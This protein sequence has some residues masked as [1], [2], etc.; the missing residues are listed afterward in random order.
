MA[1]VYVCVFGH[2]FVV[3]WLLRR[4]DSTKEVV[5]NFP[6]EWQWLERYQFLSLVAFRMH[7]R[8]RLIT[9]R[10]I[11]FWKR[12]PTTPSPSEFKEHLVNA[13]GHIYAPGLLLGSSVRGREI[14]FTYLFQLVKFCA[15]VI[16]CKNSLVKNPL[17]LH[18]D[19]FSPY[20]DISLEKRNKEYKNTQSP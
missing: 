11:G 3:R 4:D 8:K 18:N 6:K 13:S 12:L 10:V 15:H 17:K 19:A 14:I 20:F 1:C 16:L 5:Y 7:I 2:I 9:G